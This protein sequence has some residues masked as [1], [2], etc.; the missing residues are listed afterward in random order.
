MQTFRALHRDLLDDP[1]FK[2]LYEKECHAC[3]QT[4]GIFA[5]LHGEKIALKSIASELNIDMKDLRL[6]RDG[7]YCS[8][9][10][11]TRLCR[12]LDLPLPERCPR[13]VS[14]KG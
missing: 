5:E 1:E 13:A 11:V 7:D 9:P 10:M 6:L 8:P 4:M 12:H 2:D 14:R 3:T